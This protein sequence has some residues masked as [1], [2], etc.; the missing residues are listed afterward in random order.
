MMAKWIPTEERTFLA[1]LIFSGGNLGMVIALSVSGVLADEFGWEWIFYFF[2]AA[3]CAW[4]VLW[5][6]FCFESPSEH[7]RITKVWRF[8]LK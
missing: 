8:L 4:F 1:A 6:F 2:G 5:A 7:P 3:G